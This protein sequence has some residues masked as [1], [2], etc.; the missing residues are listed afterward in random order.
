ME[1]VSPSVGF[2]L[3]FILC[4]LLFQ[5]TNRAPRGVPASDRRSAGLQ[6]DAPVRVAVVAS[7]GR[8]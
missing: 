6:S 1:Q 7:R 2:R 8:P 5:F 4:R 3:T